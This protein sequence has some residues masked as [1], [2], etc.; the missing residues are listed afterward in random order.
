MRVLGIDLIRYAYRNRKSLR[1][2]DYLHLLSGIGVAAYNLSYWRTHRSFL[3][4]VP[5][6]SAAASN[7]HARGKC[8]YTGHVVN[9]ALRLANFFRFHR[10]ESEHR[11][12]FDAHT[13]NDGAG[14]LCSFS[15][16]S[17][18][19]PLRRMKLRTLFCTSGTAAPKPQM[20]SR[21]PKRRPLPSLC[22]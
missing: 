14:S 16:F 19:N 9:R 10:N 17:A 6:T 12:P 21:K 22:L 18:G 8:D 11:R 20:R 1:Q 15:A 13:A 2:R 5:G 4:G 3:R 7:K